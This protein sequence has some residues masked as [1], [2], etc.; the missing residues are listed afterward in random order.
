[1][2]DHYS[3]LFAHIRRIICKH[4]TFLC[5]AIM[6]EIISPGVLS[7]ILDPVFCLHAIHITSK[8]QPAFQQK[9]AILYGLK[10][11]YFLVETVQ[12]HVRSV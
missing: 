12:F 10:F 2:Y 9:L 4:L 11:V 6:S 5:D 8:Y 1:M 7:A 3:S